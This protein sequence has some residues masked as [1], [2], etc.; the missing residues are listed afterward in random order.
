MKNLFA[1]QGDRFL[2]SKARDDAISS[3][4]KDSSWEVKIITEPITASNFTWTVNSNEVFGTKNKVFVLDEIM[5]EPAE[6]IIP[7][8]KNLSKT[9]ALIFLF[10]EKQKLDKRT[11]IGK[12]LSE[13]VKY[14]PSMFNDKGYLDEKQ[15]EKSK[16]IIRE[17]VGWNGS[18]ECLDFIIEKCDYQY[19][20]TINEIEKINTFLGYDPKC[21]SEIKDIICMNDLVRMEPVFEKI[22]KRDLV[23][24]LNLMQEILEGDQFRTYYMMFFL[25]LLDNFSFMLYCKMAKESGSG[26]L[27]ELVNFVSE[28][29][30]KAGK[31][32]LTQTVRGR[33]FFVKDH[34][35]YWNISEL[36]FAISK[37]EDSIKACLLGIRSDRFIVENFLAQ[38]M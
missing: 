29:Y 32:M 22:K 27:D 9:R 33:Y 20:A 2:C 30:I 15:L 21:L 6:D 38:T 24:S 14:F 35:K 36:Q 1:F 16:P 12:L 26:E 10:T 37:I 7:L 18:D 8:L 23:G 13:E 3:L 28:N 11:K 31:K 4:A 25:G 19:G 5:P 34:L 17:M